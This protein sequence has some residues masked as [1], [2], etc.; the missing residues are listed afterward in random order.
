MGASLPLL[1]S[2]KFSSQVLL[3]PRIRGGG[4]GNP[5]TCILLFKERPE[6]SAFSLAM[7]FFTFTSGSSQGMIRY[8]LAAPT[9]FW[10]LA[11]WGKHPAF[12]RVWTLISILLLGLEAMLF[13]F[14]FWVA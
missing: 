9:L 12:D 6:L 1:L 2:G 11:R 14:N 7:I 4:F 5:H 10:I 13:S 3:H 8:V